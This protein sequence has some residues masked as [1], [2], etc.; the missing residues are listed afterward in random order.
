MRVLTNALLYSLSFAVAAY[1]LVAYSMLPLGAVVHPEMLPDF[2]AR[3]SAL[4]VHAFAASV[5]LLLGPWQFSAR[6]RQ[7]RPDVHRWTGRIYLA[8]GVLVGGLSGLYLAQSAFGG[9]MARLGF[10]TLAVLWLLT[11]AAAFL[12]IRNGHVADHRRWMMRN[13][14]LTFAAVM[15]R[16]YV[17]IAAAVGAE[18]APSYALIAWLCWLP[19]LL[20]AEW[21]WMRSAVRG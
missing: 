21:L 9:A 2:V 13:F 7:K 3:P 16:M 6:L 12:A 17:P 5:A 18:F 10:A 15:L 1:A 14:A 4:Y 11:G 20:V 8:V 19:N